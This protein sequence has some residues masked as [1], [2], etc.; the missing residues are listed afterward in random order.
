MYGKLF[1]RRPRHATVV[2]YLALFIALGG[3]AYAANEWT[4]DNIV[5]ESLTGADIQGA[6]GTAVAPAVNGSLTTDDV[7]GQQADPANGTPFVD[8]TLTTWDIK[9][10]SLK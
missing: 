7:A 6:A 10:H 1:S 9:D 8:G 4:G 5:D 2:A 3:T